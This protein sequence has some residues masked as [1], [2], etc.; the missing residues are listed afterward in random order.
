MSIVNYMHIVDTRISQSHAQPGSIPT[1]T[2]DSKGH[3]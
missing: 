3:S 2:L 1:Q